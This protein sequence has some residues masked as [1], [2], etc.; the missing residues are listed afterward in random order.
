VRCYRDEDPVGAWT[1]SVKDRQKN[2]KNGTFVSW[3]MSLWGESIDPSL[4]VPYRLPDDDELDL[5]PPP[6]ESQSSSSAVPSESKTKTIVKPTAHLPEDHAQS[7]GEAHLPIDDQLDATSVPSTSPPS[8]SETNAGPVSTTSPLSSSLSGAYLGNMAS[9]L[10]NQAWVFIAAGVV[11]VFAVSLIAFFVIRRRNAQ[12]RAGRQGY[13]FESLRGDEF[14]DEEED[15]PM[16]A[17]DSRRGARTT[18][19][20]SKGGSSGGGGKGKSTSA[21]TRELFD[22]FGADDSSS[23]EDEET[24]ALVRPESMDDRYMEDFLADEPPPRTP[25]SEAPPSPAPPPP[26][27]PTSGTTPEEEQ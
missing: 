1:L 13:F 26:R 2:D 7:S 3:K 27:S 19:S 22:A 14:G 24:T 8:P 10:A 5:P 20:S 9:L 15:H 17:L 11:L 6:A 25:L 21:R 18:T 4:A 12:R 16:E 23:E